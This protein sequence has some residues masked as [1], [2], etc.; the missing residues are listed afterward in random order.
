MTGW[1]SLVTRISGN[2]HP[3]YV[4]GLRILTFREHV[5]CVLCLVLLSIF[6]GV[7]INSFNYFIGG[8]D[9]KFSGIL[10]SAFA[11]FIASGSWTP[12]LVPLTFFKILGKKRISAIM[13]Y[14]VW[15]A[16]SFIVLFLGIYKNFDLQ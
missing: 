4:D 7:L 15:L 14:E 9:I 13:I 3:K 12:I 10:G 16:M 5:L 8:Y 1:K 6:F 11:L 2:D